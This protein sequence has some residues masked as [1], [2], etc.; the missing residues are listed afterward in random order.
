MQEN[1]WTRFDDIAKPEEV[2]SAKSS[3]TPI[4]AGRYVAVLEKIEAGESQQGTPM[5]KVQFRTDTNK[6]IFYNQVLQNLSNPDITASNIAK[7]SSFVDSLTGESVAFTGLGAFAE[8]IGQI[9]VGK[10]YEVQVS[11]GKKDLECKFAIV[12]VLNEVTD[13]ESDGEEIPF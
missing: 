11:Y 5:L 9:E 8:R 4:D 1:L 12:R 3:F 13:S 10:T 6:M 7:A 2:E